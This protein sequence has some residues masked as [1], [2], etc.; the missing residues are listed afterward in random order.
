MAAKRSAL[1][2]RDPYPPGHDDRKRPTLGERRMEPPPPPRFD[3][4]STNVGGPG[5]SRSGAGN[6][7]ESSDLMSSKKR[8]YGGKR[9]DIRKNDARGAGGDFKRGSDFDIMPRHSSGSGGHM[10]HPS[11]SGN[12]HACFFFHIYFIFIC[13]NLLS[14]KLKILVSYLYCMYIENL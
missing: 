9:D 14:K 8:D 10:M 6:Y 11:K 1:D 7:G 12:N 13:F 3:Q 2:R 4:V 5:Q